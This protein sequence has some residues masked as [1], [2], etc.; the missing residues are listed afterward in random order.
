MTQ[1]AT[2]SKRL[3]HFSIDIA[4]KA[5]GYFLECSGLGSEHEIV[6]Q[7][8]VNDQ[9]QEMILK[10]PGRLKWENIV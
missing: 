7:K 8:V 1:T 5:I 10:I 2:Q 9:G 6:E 3:F 4:D